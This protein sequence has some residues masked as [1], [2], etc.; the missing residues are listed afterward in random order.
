MKSRMDINKAEP[1][2]YLAMSAA[3][4]VVKGFDID[5]KLK[6][7]IKVRVSQINGCGYCI[8]YHTKDALALGE[9]NQRLF[10]L[11]AWWETP[12]FTEEEQAAL[13]LA[14]EVTRI[15]HGVSDDTYQTA[16]KFFGEQKL[17]QLIFIAITINSWN[18]VAIPV[19][20]VA[21]QG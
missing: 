13:K 15:S 5:R 9:T 11:S 17:A 8:N 6:E 19:H 7:L 16:L 10:A 1:G 3:D 18:R 21:E 4:K 14:E 2:I 20:M 12:F